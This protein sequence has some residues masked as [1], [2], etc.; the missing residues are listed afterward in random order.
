MFNSY[1]SIPPAQLSYNMQGYYHYYYFYS[2]CH[3]YHLKSG[4]ATLYMNLSIRLKKSDR[5]IQLAYI[6]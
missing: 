3:Y 2:I 5:I 1:F 6:V 4:K